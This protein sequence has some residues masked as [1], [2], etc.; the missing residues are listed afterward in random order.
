MECEGDRAPRVRGAGIGSKADP[1]F[2]Q[3]NKYSAERFQ[4]ASTLC[5]DS[6][7][8]VLG[9]EVDGLAESIAIV[10]GSHL[11]MAV[12]PM[13][14]LVSGIAGRGIQV[15]VCPSLQWKE[16]PILWM[17]AC[18]EPGQGEYMLFFLSITRGRSRE[19]SQASGNA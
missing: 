9:V 1:A 5:P 8:E 16:R 7:S 10:S 18:A 12:A 4:L 14:S 19:A 6:V 13:L 2:L 11:W 17:V 15:G 3:Q